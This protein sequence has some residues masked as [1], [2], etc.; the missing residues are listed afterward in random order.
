M[1]LLFFA[2]AILAS[3]S[4]VH[5]KSTKENKAVSAPGKYVVLQYCTDQYGAVTGYGNTCGNGGMSCVPHS[6]YSD[7]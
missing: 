5:S 2:F 6:C 7:K 4:V 1:K 3:F